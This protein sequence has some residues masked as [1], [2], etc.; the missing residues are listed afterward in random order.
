MSSFV[1]TEGSAFNAALNPQLL[2]ESLKMERNKNTYFFKMTTELAPGDDVPE[3]VIMKK[4]EFVSEGRDSMIMPLMRRLKN[5]ATIGDKQ[6]LG[7]EETQKTETT[8][9]RINVTKHAVRSPGRASR[10]RS[11]KLKLFQQARPQLGQWYGLETDFEVYGALY[12]G[13]SRNVS[14][15]KVDGGLGFTQD[16]TSHPNFYVLGI[17]N[18][19][20]PQGEVLFDD[21][22][23]TYETNVGTAVNDMIVAGAGAA[24]AFSLQALDRLIPFIENNEIEPIN[25]GNDRMYVALLHTNTW[26]QAAEADAQWWKLLETIGVRGDENPIFTGAKGIYKGQFIIHVSPHV[27]GVTR[28]S[29]TP[30]YGTTTRHSVFDTKDI[31]ANLILG[32]GAVNMAMGEELQFNEET[33]DYGNFQGVQAHEIWGTA[34]ADWK[35]HEPVGLAPTGRQGKN[36]SSLVFCTHS[37]LA[38]FTSS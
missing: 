28:P 21:T 6:M 2:D 37:G 26:Q 34:R 16:Y 4:T 33:I 24:N 20:A 27:H 13:V 31:K 25:V 7:S 11:K 36:I 32:R 14:A 30:V 38:N 19:N 18:A 17:D 23:A 15:A 3:N 10:Q 22:P 35:S 12:E 5:E 29:T 8:E 9:V 1:D